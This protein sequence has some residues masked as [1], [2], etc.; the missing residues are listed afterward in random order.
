MTY[1]QFTLRQDWYLENEIVGQKLKQLLF[2]KGHKFSANEEGEYIIE[3]FA[4]RLVLDT[5]RMRLSNDNGVLLFD[6]EYSNF[7]I[8][9]EEVPED[10]DNLIGNWRIQLDVKTTRKKLKEV[11]KIIDEYVRPIV[12]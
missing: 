6:E 4:G 3:S 8:V 5:E 7:E 10:D 2:K 1:P 11:Q 12:S 9:I